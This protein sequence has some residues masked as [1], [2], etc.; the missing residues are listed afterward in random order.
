[1]IQTHSKIKKQ[2][3]PL[4]GKVS[5]SQGKQ[6]ESQVSES[7]GKAPQ[8]KEKPKHSL[9]KSKNKSKIQDGK[10]AS[11]KVS[12]EQKSNQKNVEQ[13]KEKSSYTLKVEKT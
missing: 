4:Q 11:S 13:D 9:V 2:S 3:K 10:P 6:G 5:D 7:K 1:M 8:S 12:V